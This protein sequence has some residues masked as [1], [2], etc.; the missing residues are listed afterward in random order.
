MDG[1]LR[2]GGRVRKGGFEVSGPTPTRV[3][4]AYREAN[5]IALFGDASRARKALHQAERAAEVLSAG[6]SGVSIWSFSPG[7]QALFFLSV[8]LHTGD[9]AGALPQPPKPVGTAELRRCW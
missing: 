8:A 1:R 4:L 2:R 3:E 6:A 9:A 7:R 5:A